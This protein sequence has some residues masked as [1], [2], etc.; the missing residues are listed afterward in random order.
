MLFFQR[1]N[2][3]LHWLSDLGSSWVT[4]FDSICLCQADQMSDRKV[5][6]PLQPM[7]KKPKKSL[8][9]AT[10]NSRVSFGS[11]KVVSKVKELTCSYIII[12]DT[13]GKQLIMNPTQIS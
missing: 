1:I 9:S 12:I 8:E 13:I 6:L 10:Q 7:L 11:T 4:I 2:Y 3:E 5:S